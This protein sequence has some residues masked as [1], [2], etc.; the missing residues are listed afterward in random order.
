MKLEV[1]MRIRMLV[2]DSYSSMGV[3]DTFFFF[4]CSQDCIN[5]NQDCN[6]SYTSLSDGPYKFIAGCVIEA[7]V[8]AMLDSASSEWSLIM[9]LTSNNSNVK[10]CLQGF[11]SHYFCGL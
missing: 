8:C 2:K 7:V 10:W 5:R 4:F 3:L 9:C 11:F 1:K 6:M